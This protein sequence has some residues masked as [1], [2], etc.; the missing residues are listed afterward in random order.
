MFPFIL[1]KE[2]AKE[3]GI[4]FF[5]SGRACKNGHMSPRYTSTHMCLECRRMHETSRISRDPEANR[6]KARNWCAANR[7]KSR[8]MSAAYKAKNSDA[9]LA[10]SRR[11]YRE[12]AEVRCAKASQWRKE[13]PLAVR[14]YANARRARKALNGGSHTAQ[15]IADI[16][17]LQKGRCAY[18]RD[19]LVK[20]HV[21]HIEPLVRGGSNGRSNLQMLCVPCNGSKSA[22]DPIEF[23]QS[24]GMLL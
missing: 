21:D 20:Y 12:N 22:R 9:L 10:K 7:E 16:M 19:V 5:F 13:N 2:E 17:K 6:A 11:R 4:K 14:A 18:C 24:K 3:L 8:G 23:A 1:H 15:D